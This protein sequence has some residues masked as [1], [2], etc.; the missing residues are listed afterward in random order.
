MTVR[1][2]EHAVAKVAERP[3]RDAANERLVVDGGAG[4]AASAPQVGRLAALMRDRGLLAAMGRRARGLV[5]PASAERVV[6][7]ALRRALATADPV[8]A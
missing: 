7:V 6:A 2:F 5:L 3:N 8:A 1:C 4:Y